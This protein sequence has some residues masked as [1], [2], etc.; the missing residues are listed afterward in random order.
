M[1]TT[2]RLLSA[3]ALFLSVCSATII[4]PAQ[5]ASWTLNSQHKVQWDTAGLQA[6]LQMHLCAGGATDVSQS[7]ATLARK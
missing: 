5:N 4:S 3:A 1:S 7:I 2:T 6:P